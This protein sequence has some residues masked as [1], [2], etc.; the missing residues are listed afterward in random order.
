MSETP[1]TRELPPSG[2]WE[3]GVSLRSRGSCGGGPPPD[4][5]ELGCRSAVVSPVNV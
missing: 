4:A 3:R 5:P 2:S 1:R